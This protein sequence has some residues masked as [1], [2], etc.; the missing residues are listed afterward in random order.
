[1]VPQ[2]LLN[3]EETVEL[4]RELS[5]HPGLSTAC[6]GPDFCRQYLIFH[7]GA[8]IVYSGPA[9]TCSEIKDE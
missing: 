7:D 2:V 8:S 3:T 4:Y 9:G 6:L 1:R 5:Q